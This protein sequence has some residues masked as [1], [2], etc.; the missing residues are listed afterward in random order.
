MAARLAR[1]G[2][3]IPLAAASLSLATVAA[4]KLPLSSANFMPHGY[5]Y[6]WERRILWLNV[7]SD[8]LITLSYYAIPVI[9]IYFTRRNRTLPFNHIF[10]MFGTFILACGTTHLMEIWNVWHGSY[11][12]AGAIKGVT[13]MVSV[14][15]AGMLIPLLPHVISVPDRVQLQILNC[16]LEQEI[17]ERKR[18]EQAAQESLAHSGSVLQELTEQKFALDQHAIVA[19]TD[20]Q[21][22]ITYVNAKFCA[23]S[24]YSRDELIGLN[25][26]ILN[27]GHHPK[28]FF[29]QMYHAIA[30]GQ[31]W[32]GEICNRAKDGSLYWVDTTIVPFLEADGKPRQYMAIRAD[33]TERKRAEEMRERLAAVVDSSDDAIIG[34]TLDGTINAWNRGAE[35]V[36]G[37]AASEVLGKRLLILFPPD[38]V[39]EEFDI[40]A[41]LGHGESVEHFET[42]RVRKDG[43][44]I[45]I[46]ATISPI[47]NSSGAIV[48]A[49]KIARDI[50]ERKRVD[51]ALA[52]QAAEL[53]R[54]ANELRSSQRA[55]E[56]QKLML[57]SSWTV[58]RRGWSPLMSREDSLSG[59]LLQPGLLAWVPQMWAVRNGLYTM[60]SICPML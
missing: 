27:S 46:S 51:V 24:Q 48:G 4:N 17:A 40:L 47:R 19:T 34:K 23:I 45:D 1:L 26:R 28:E 14:L 8:G 18:A 5:C 33:I 21:G 44:K 3:A 36:F 57:Q 30:N 38:R 59:T 2:I 53:S 25:H 49:S 39:D 29:Q 6:L 50:T 7:I 52:D 9:L 13:A 41:R 60:A 10:W 32:R 56:S 43:R 15:T 55:L 31:V 37:Y 12:L 58:W 54:Q 22:I 20:V 35:K 11:V 42:V 16:Q